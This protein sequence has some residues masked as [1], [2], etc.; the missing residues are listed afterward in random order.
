MTHNNRAI[1]VADVGGCRVLSASDFSMH[2]FVERCRGLLEGRLIWITAFDGTPL[3]PTEEEKALGWSDF[4]NVAVSPLVTADL[5]LPCSGYGDE[6]WVDV[7]DHVPLRHT[8]LAGFVGLPLAGLTK[9]ADEGLDRDD[10]SEWFLWYSKLQ[11]TFWTGFWKSEAQM[12][13]GA[14]DPFNFV[15]RERRVFESVLEA[16]RSTP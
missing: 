9:R 2:D 3:C 5:E 14:G 10:E 16:I 1:E 6:W 8:R 13:I 7:Q 15:A 11:Q 4:E 12:Y